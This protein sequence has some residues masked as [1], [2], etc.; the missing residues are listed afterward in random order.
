MATIS[1]LEDLEVW[2]LSRD[3]VKRVYALCEKP[4]VANDRF[5]A[6][7]AK[8]AAVSCM[9]NIAEG[10]GCPTN[11]DFA[12]FLGMSCGSAEELVSHAHVMLDVGYI[13][14]AHFNEITELARRIIRGNSSLSANLRR[15]G[16]SRTRNR[17][18]EKPNDRKTE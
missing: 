13:T 7:Q 9:A 5:L 15:V 18:T 8:R 10:Y 11:L 16:N 3:L 17:Q 4:P 6:S 12:R 1:S 14:R 2:Q